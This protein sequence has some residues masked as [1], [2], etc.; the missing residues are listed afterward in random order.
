MDTFVYIALAL[1]GIGAVTF[2]AAYWP[3]Y[4]GRS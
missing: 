1:G 3:I 4:R 2:F